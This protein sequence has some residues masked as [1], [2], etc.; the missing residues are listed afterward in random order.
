M[1]TVYILVSD[2]LDWDDIV[3]Y[4]SVEEAIDASKKHPT[5]RVEIFTKTSS[6]YKPTYDYYKN[7]G[8]VIHT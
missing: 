5:N 6:G 1:E 8:L 4:L 7:G 3:V 2:G